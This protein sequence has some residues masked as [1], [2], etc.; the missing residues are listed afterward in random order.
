MLKMHEKHL[1][2]GRIA[3]E[4]DSRTPNPSLYEYRPKD[5]IAYQVN[6]EW[7]ISFTYLNNA[8]YELHLKRGGVREFSSLNS[9]E[10]CLKKIGV[11]EFKVIL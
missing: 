5:F 2:E 8:G 10:R 1:E 4:I 3:K 9:A 11:K 7:Q 6:N